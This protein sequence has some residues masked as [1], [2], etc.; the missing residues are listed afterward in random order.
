[1]RILGILLVGALSSGCVSAE[2]AAS[3]FT[4]RVIDTETGL[5]V[6]NAVVQTI[7]EHQY[8]PW[9]NK[10]SIVD[11]RKEPVDVNGEIVFKGKCIHGGA[12]GT[13]FAEGYY[14]SHNGQSSKK[15]SL[16]NRWE[17]WNPIIEVK[18]RPKKNPVPMVHKGM[19]REKVPLTTDGSVGYDLGTGDWIAP[20]GKGK[21]SDLLFT[22]TNVTEPKKGIRYTLSFPNPLD[23]IQ[24]YMPP[25]D[26]R[27]SYIFPYEAPTNGYASS[28]NKYRLLKYPVLSDYPANNLKENINY[29]FRVRTQ[30]DKDGNIV[31]AHYG[32][33]K[34]E[35][36]LSSTPLID[37]RYWFN[38]DPQSRSL[39][40]DKKPY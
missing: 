8:D 18:M 27:S 9:G 25:E 17:P 14:S 16:L 36:T 1:M 30:V 12:G 10:P 26:L 11:R 6:T 29:I 33:I 22:I 23:G 31:S 20:Y 7:F 38:P 13:A 19:L 39:E 4:V 37:L 2:P 21:T 28:L 34:G 24:E 35:V 32:C 5:P 15:N 40:S 3:K